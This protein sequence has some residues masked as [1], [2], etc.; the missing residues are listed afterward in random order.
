M[1][2]LLHDD[3]PSYLVHGGKQ[4][5][6]QK[7]YENLRAQGIDVEYARW[8][9]PSQKCDL[10]H[11]LGCSPGM[12][13][14]AQQAKVKL[15]LTHIVDATS[16]SWVSQVY[17]RFRNQMIRG[18]HSNRIG[19]LFQWYAL[20]NIDALV[21]VNKF[22]LEAAVSIYGVPRG[23][24]HII[25]HGCDR[26]TIVQ[27][28]LGPKNEQSYLVCVASIVPRKNTVLLAK[29]ARLADIPIVFLGK[30]F[31]E[32]DS[33]Y[34]D[35]IK[36]VDDKRVIYSGYVSEEEKA[37]WLIEA[38]GFVLLS[39]H[40]S[41]CIA[42]YE[43]AAAGLPLL[44]S[45]LP[46]AHSYGMHSTI[47]HIALN[48]VTLIASRLKSFF[49]ASKRLKSPTFPVLTWEEIARQYIDVYQGT[50]GSGI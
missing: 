19:S 41:G 29:V 44:L 6:A 8:W 25:P 15:V 11:S 34:L 37:H 16:H 35:F 47:Q 49:S 12:V 31:S 48:D 45:D 7:L 39:K 22:D 10:I 17:R 38:S 23:K 9:D 4:V 21:Y 18:L 14:A 24:A 46:W 43:A 30:P 3:T 40:E 5:H 27:L 2:I 1:K 33:Y 32:N 42:V 20:P 13:W 26:D 36:L 50:L 28:Q